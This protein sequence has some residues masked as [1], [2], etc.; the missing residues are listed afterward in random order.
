MNATNNTQTPD[1]ATGNQTTLAALY[2]Q[3]RELPPRYGSKKDV[4]RMV[5]MSV[6]S[7][8][9]FLR[10]G[11]PALHIGKR[12]VRFDLE[13][14]RAWLADNYRVVRRAPAKGGAQ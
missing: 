2:A 12:R 5:Q 3:G 9:N 14:V 10:E 6:R 11:C 7:V 1:A 4:A 8:D 13:E